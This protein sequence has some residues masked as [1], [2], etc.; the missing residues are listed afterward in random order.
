MT[1]TQVKPT[2]T[3]LAILCCS[4]ALTGCKDTEQEEAV[5]EAAELRIQLEKAKADLSKVTSERDSIGTQLAAITQARDK[6]QAAAEKGMNVMEQLA[7][8]TKER[9]SA[10]AKAADA[11]GMVDKLKGQLQEQIQKTVGLQEQNKKLQDSI[12]E[13]QKKFGGEANLPSLLK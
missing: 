5:A 9:D 4:L 10:L 6:L 1:K 11:Q 13:L 8:L 3:V 7:S 12:A 2:I